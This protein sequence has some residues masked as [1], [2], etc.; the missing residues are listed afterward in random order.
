MMKRKMSAAGVLL[1]LVLLSAASLVQ[2]ADAFD[3]PGIVEPDWEATLA[4]VVLGR[5]EKIDV[6]EGATVHKGEVLVRLDSALEQLDVSR[7]QVVADN[8]VELD[9]AKAKLDVMEPAFKRTDELHQSGSLSQD[10]YDKALLDLRMAEAEYAQLQQREKVEALELDLAREQ[11]RRRIITAPRDAV[12][13]EIFPEEG[14]VCEPRQPIVRL[15]DARTV[16][17]DLDIESEKT[18]GLVKGMKVPVR[19]SGPDGIVTAE[20]T[21]EFVSPAVDAASGLRRVRVRIDNGDGKILPGVSAT[22]T[23]NPQ[24]SGGR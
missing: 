18:A 4:T 21:V 23:F 7:R 10:D 11:V 17:V 13:I 14:E 24:E 1:Q 8:K 6:K 2:G 16:K 9:L 19:I 5:V 12:V 3:V 22:V 20:G 15:V